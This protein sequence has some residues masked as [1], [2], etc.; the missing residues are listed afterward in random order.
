MGQYTQSVVTIVG[1]II[2]SYYGY[3]ELGAFLGSNE[4]TTLTRNVPAS[5][6]RPLADLLEGMND[7]VA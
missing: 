5:G 3:P 6:P 1:T 7:D 4:G 2:G